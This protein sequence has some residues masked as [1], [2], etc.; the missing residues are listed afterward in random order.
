MGRLI[1]RE[2]QFQRTW[3]GQ[4]KGVHE[5]CSRQSATQS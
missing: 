4:L 2:Q 3:A 5:A 1:P